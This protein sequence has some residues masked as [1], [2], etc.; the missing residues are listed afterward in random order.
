MVSS[1]GC[2]KCGYIRKSGKLSCCAHGG[3][4]FKNCGNAGDTKFEHTWSEGIQA[5]K[6]AAKPDSM[7]ASMQ[8]MSRR[9]ADELDTT[10]TRNT[11]GQE[12]SVGD[13]DNK[14]DSDITESKGCVT[15]ARFGVAS[16]VLLI[17]VLL[18]S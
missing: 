13:F 18:Q 6:D 1:S 8:I 10:H 17:I 7:K 12:I 2:A 3:D 11:T 5:C 15:F 4:W 14:S 9:V 16:H